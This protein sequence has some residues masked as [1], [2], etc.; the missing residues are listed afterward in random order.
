MFYLSLIAGTLGILLFHFGIFFPIWVSIGIFVISASYLVRLVS[1]HRTGPLSLLIFL[2]FSLPFIHLVP[3]LWFDFA[4]YPDDLWGL[5]ANPYMTDPAIIELMGMIGAVGVLGFL[6]GVYQPG[7]G[8]FRHQFPASNNLRQRTLSIAG[9]LILI[10]IAVAISWANAPAETIFGADYTKSKSLIEGF[11][12]PSI[13]MFSYILILFCVADAIFETQ[14]RIRKLKRAVLLAA[15]VIIVFWFQLLRGDREC[16][17]AV[18]GGLMMYF[19]WGT[20]DHRR[21]LTSGWKIYCFAIFAAFSIHAIS[22]ITGIARSALSE[23][24][25][26]SE[27]PAL[28][29]DLIQVGAIRTDSLL[30]GTWSGVLMTPLSIAGDYLNGS[31]AY[32]YGQTYLDLLASVIPGFVADFIGYARP[33]DGSMGPAWKMTYGIGG[34][35]GVVIP[36]M[37]F[38]MS[39]VFLIVALWSFVLSR[40]ERHV[41][42]KPS[43]PHLALLGTIVMAAPHWLWYGEKNILN[44]LTIYLVCLVAYKLSASRGATMQDVNSSCSPAHCIAK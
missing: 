4:S 40:L 15:S 12:F 33:I 30:S 44:A 35:H 3:Y 19:V 1:R 37:A 39:G 24:T 32:D 23:L 34:T 31:L 42:R 10:A 7:Q 41:I 20:S 21:K 28:I 25:N 13:W 6:V 17:P 38:G 9:F 36:F 18:V 27:I 5:Q 26:L 11:N 22:H 14:Q 43:I 2:V 16:L 8:V 29:D